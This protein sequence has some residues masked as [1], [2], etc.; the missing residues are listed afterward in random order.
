M[1]DEEMKKLHSNWY[2]VPIVIE[3]C[4]LWKEECDALSNYVSSHYS[5]PRFRNE[6]FEKSL[7]TVR[8]IAYSIHETGLDPEFYCALN[9]G[10]D[11]F[12]HKWKVSCRGFD[13][14]RNIVSTNIR[15]YDD[16]FIIRYYETYPDR[17]CYFVK[18]I[19][20]LHQDKE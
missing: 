13:V 3:F 6:K 19:K 17:L 16:A 4:K 14:E 18:M 11:R 2:G 9:D 8:Q 1:I 5:P 10:M 15:R 20:E 7:S 12:L